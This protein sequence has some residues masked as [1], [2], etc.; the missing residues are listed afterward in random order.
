MSEKTKDSRFKISQVRG[1]DDI[2]VTAARAFPAARLRYL[3]LHPHH[4]SR[5]EAVGLVWVA[6]MVLCVLITG[7]RILA[8]TEEGRGGWC[9][10]T[11]GLAGLPWTWELSRWRSC[12]VEFS[13][14]NSGFKRVVCLVLVVPLANWL[15][16][17]WWYGKENGVAGEPGKA[18]S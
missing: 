5:H 3:A 15:S 4:V 16:G 14:T 6:F 10:T 2:D 8:F 11:E 17:L 12:A 9:P 1:A 13:Q 7:Y 18:R